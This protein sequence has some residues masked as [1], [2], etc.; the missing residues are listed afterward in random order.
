M[1][2]NVEQVYESPTIYKIYVPLTGN[3]LKN[4]NCYVL[5]DQGESLVIDTGFNNHEC[6]DAL[7]GGLAELGVSPE[8]TRLF[9]THLHSDHCGLAEYFDHPDTTIYM[10]EKEYQTLQDSFSGKVFADLNKRLLSEGFPEE[11][12]QAANANNPARVFMPS[13]PFPVTFVQDREE[14]QVG[15]VTLRVMLMPGHTPGQMIL[16]MPSEKLMFTADHV[17]FDITPNITTWPNMRNSLGAYMESLEK[18]LACDVE[19]AFPGHRNMSNKTLAQRIDEIKRHHERRLNEIREVLRR[20]PS[21]NAYDVASHLT[22]S[23][24]GAT[25]DTAPKQQKWFA[26]GETMAH[27]DY[28]RYSLHEID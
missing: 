5:I 23:L 6:R 9:I 21:T 3:A 19:T 2:I 24:H 28:M 17:L 27:L 25:W 4:L 22:W 14:L 12:L 16:Y 10:G 13:Y 11:E 26:V 1:L 15:S 8:H 20:N 18:V 7:L